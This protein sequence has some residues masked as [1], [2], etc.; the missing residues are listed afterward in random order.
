MLL[1]FLH[2]L[3]YYFSDVM[4][5]DKKTTP[6]DLNSELKKNYGYGLLDISYLIAEILLEDFPFEGSSLHGIRKQIIRKAKEELVKTEKNFIDM[7]RGYYAHYDLNGKYHELTGEIEKENFVKNEFPQTFEKID[8][9]TQKWKAIMDNLDPNFKWRPKNKKSIIA[10]ILKTNWVDTV[11]ILKWFYTHLKGA[12]YREKLR[13]KCRINEEIKL[14]KRAQ[15]RVLRK[16]LKD[17]V[18]LRHLFFPEERFSRIN[19][20]SFRDIYF[21]KFIEFNR[22][23]IKIKSII[24][25]LKVEW[26]RQII[27]EKNIP[28]FSQSKR[29]IESLTKQD[30]PYIIFPEGTK[31]TL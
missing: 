27:F 3:C 7:L 25:D 10:S 6:Q 29:K 30:S 31:V 26:F 14:L 19:I 5:F 22:K 2:F 24:K 11:N 13:T 1:V 15:Q 23:S 28:N 17:I 9:M 20:K 18:I 16:N 12:D 4:N 21:I 8:H